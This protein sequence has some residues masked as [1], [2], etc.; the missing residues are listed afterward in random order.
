[1]SNFRRQYQ[2]NRLTADG[3][4]A[5]ALLAEGKTVTAIAAL[6]GCSRGRVYA[7][8]R[9]AAGDAASVASVASMADPMLE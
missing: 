6:L 3:A 8:M 7:A 1:M 9:A 2:R 4:R 5:R